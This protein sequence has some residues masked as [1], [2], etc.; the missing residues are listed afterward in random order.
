MIRHPGRPS[1]VL[2]ESGRQ[3][4]RPTSISRRTEGRS[5]PHGA[6]IGAPNWRTNL[7]VHCQRQH[8]QFLPRAPSLLLPA[9]RERYSS[10]FGRVQSFLTSFIYHRAQPVRGAD[11]SMSGKWSTLIQIHCTQ[12]NWP[13]LRPR[14]GHFV[15][16]S[17]ETRIQLLGLPIQLRAPSYSPIP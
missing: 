3:R 7:V 17:T 5:T 11:V 4:C 16:N 9:L 15:A 2:G 14:G 13:C 6:P 10:K 8:V 12:P 1:R